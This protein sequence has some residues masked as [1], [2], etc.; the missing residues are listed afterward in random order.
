MFSLR[1]NDG[2]EAPEGAKKKSNEQQNLSFLLFPSTPNVR[3][4]SEEV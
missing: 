1:D 2:T 4:M 3:T